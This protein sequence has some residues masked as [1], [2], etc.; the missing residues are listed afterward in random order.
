MKLRAIS[1]VLA[2]VVLGSGPPA[3]AQDAGVE[4]AAVEEAPSVGALPLEDPTIEP[5]RDEH[6]RIDDSPEA[7]AEVA[8]TESSSGPAADPAEGPDARAAGPVEDPT[9]HHDDVE[10]DGDAP[11]P[12]EGQEPEEVP[13]AA[14]DQAP[15]VKVAYDR[16]LL[17]GIDDWFYLALNGLV[18]A[19]YTANYR[20]KPPTD[21]VTLEREKQVTQGFAVPRARFTLGIGLTEFVAVV[22]RIGVVAGGTIEFQRAF[23]DLKW[24]YLR[25]RAGLFMNELNAESL[26]NPNDLYF[27][28]YSIVDNVYTPGSSKGVMFTYLRRRFSINLGYSDGL[29]TGFSEIRSA[30]NADFAVTL[31]AQYSW[32]DAGL[33]GFNRLMARRGTPFGIRLG[34]AVH[35][36]DGGR[37]QGSVPAKIAM[38]TIDLSI[39]GSG[40][41]ALFSVTVGQDATDATEANEA[42]EIMSSG[43]SAMGGYFVLDDLQVFGQ[44]SVVPKPRVVGTL[45]TI[46]DAT[47]GSPSYFH[48]FGIGLSYFVIPGYDNVKLQTDFQYFLGAEQASTVPASPLNSIQPNFDGSQFSWRVQLSAAF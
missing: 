6:L 35:Y 23:I 33:A 14:A 26:V 15:N 9:L 27:L 36:Q 2:F 1:T 48:A 38:G 8:A 29:R 39:R 25:V 31:R 41:S 28:D 4:D 12:E 11:P 43:V 46:P 34:A 20:T 3:R 22:M 19:R 24:K 37:T 47:L 18:Q 16:G 44:Y 10:S 32:G 42:G 7:A 40:W 21:P 45:P 30:A 17:L 5:P 13:E